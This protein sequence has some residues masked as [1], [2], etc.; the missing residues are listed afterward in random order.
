M[1]QRDVLL[2]GRVRVVIAAPVIGV[3]E[4]RPNG[5]HVVWREG[6]C[7]GT[8][9][10]PCRYQASWNSIHVD[11]LKQEVSL[12]DVWSLRY[13]ASAAARLA[14]SI[15]VSS[16]ARLD[17]RSLLYTGGARGWFTTALRTSGPG[18]LPPAAG[19]GPKDLTNG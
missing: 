11:E 3:L 1:P 2:L 15:A 19:N 7:R 10:S 12:A 18:L 6:K 16:A 5:F 14:G 8:S 9:P 4:Q 17:P 13:A